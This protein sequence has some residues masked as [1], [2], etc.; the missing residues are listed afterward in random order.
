MTTT[1]RLRSLRGA[2]GN[3]V[4]PPRF[5]AFALLLPI[6]FLAHRHFFPA[7]RIADSAAMAFDLAA[8]IFL[9]SIAPFIWIKADGIRR[10]ADAN[11]A[12]RLLVL[13]ST[14]LITLAITGAIAGE[15]GGARQGALVAIVKLV[16]T[17]LL[18]WLFANTVYA[19]HYAHEYYSSH[20]DTGG[21]CGGIDFPGE[22]Q[23][24]YLDFLYF[25]FTLGMTFQTSDVQITASRIRGA[26]LLHCF[27]AFVF[28]LGI[29]AFTIN[30]LGGAGGG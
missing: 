9:V 20:S 6:A 18:V 5:I 19:L 17:L 10:K 15:L 24:E 26:A 16:A 4:A 28:N 22:S 2:I 13:I 25:S 29:V 8:A 23:P 14:T 27:A 3:T 21:D 11:S 7:A 30:A 1:G 12:G